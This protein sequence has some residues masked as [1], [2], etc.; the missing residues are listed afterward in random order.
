VAVSYH[1]ETLPE[2]YESR[3]R[4]Q[5]PDWEVEGWV[6]TYAAIAAGEL[7]AVSDHVERLAGHPP[8]SMADYLAADPSAIERVRSIVTTG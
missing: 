1:A 5:A 6:S 8:M 3:A 4:Y 2:A 7:D